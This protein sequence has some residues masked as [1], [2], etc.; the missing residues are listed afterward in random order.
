[1]LTG[2]VYAAVVVLWAVVLVP[3]WLRRHERNSEQRT[4]LT[5]HRAMTTLE[6]RR[7]SRGVSRAAHDMDVEVAGARSRVHDRISVPA[8][9]SPIDQHLDHGIDP[10]EGGEEEVL[11]RDVRRYRAKVRARENAARRRRQVQNGLIGFSVISILLSFMGIMPSFI[12]GLIVAGTGAFWWMARKQNEQAKVNAERLRRRETM[13][14]GQRDSASSGASESEDAT[15]RSR[16]AKSEKSR[17]RET[18]RH[19]EP[20]APVPAADADYVSADAGQLGDVRVLSEHEVTTRRATAASAMSSDQA[21]E[22]ESTEA[23][24]SASASSSVRSLDSATNASLMSQRIREQEEALMVPGADAEA[25]LGL[26]SYVDVPDNGVRDLR[27][28]RRAA[29][30]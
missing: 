16:R 9:P 12:M 7:T 14:T 10:F 17:R 20:S 5:F 2:L 22:W 6:R 25:Q 4:T 1:M 24:M 18:R 26:D 13:R 15:P 28:Y 3:Q 21:S 29:N 30:D 8:G 23:P 19:V 27:S 11:L